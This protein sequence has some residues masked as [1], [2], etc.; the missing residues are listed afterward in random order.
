MLYQLFQQYEYLTGI[1]YI[2][3]DN[4]DKLT[5]KLRKVEAALKRFDILPYTYEIAKK[6]AEIDA[7][8]IR[9]EKR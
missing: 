1:Y 2:Y 6:T 9:S 8:L 7:Y 4:P 5:E 3:L